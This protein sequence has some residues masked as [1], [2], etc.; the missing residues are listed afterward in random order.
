MSPPFFQLSLQKTTH[1]LTD[2]LCQHT[3][4]HV[5]IPPHPVIPPPTTHLFPLAKLA[6][7]HCSNSSHA[8]FICVVEKKSV[9]SN[10]A[11]WSQDSHPWVTVTHRSCLWGAPFK[12][13]GPPGLRIR[14]SGPIKPDKQFIF[15]SELNILYIIILPWTSN[16]HH[17]GM[18][19]TRST[20]THV[21]EPPIHDT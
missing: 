12:R 6:D 3:H 20:T 8:W 5:H 11:N 13:T 21:R 2:A 10:S 9:L 14:V 18:G 1:V 15:Q 7:W 4:T 19:K 17:N 16:Y